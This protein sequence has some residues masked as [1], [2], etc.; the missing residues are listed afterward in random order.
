M[1][2]VVEDLPEPKPHLA[3]DHQSG[4]HSTTT[5]K[6]TPTKS[7][8]TQTK[9]GGL[10]SNIMG[11]AL[12]VGGG[13]LLANAIGGIFGGNSK[14]GNTAM[15]QEG[16]GQQLQQLQQQIPCQ[17]HFQTFGQCLNGNKTNIGNYQWAYDILI[18]CNDNQQN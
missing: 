11:S 5:P 12:G 14:G 9:G 13:I 1:D 3:Q 8:E 16:T 2:L 4:Q 6:K 7:T 17:Q 10:F 15:M 18:E